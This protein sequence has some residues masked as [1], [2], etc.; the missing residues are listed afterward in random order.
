MK[1]LTAEEA[2]A[3]LNIKPQTVARRCRNGDLRGFKNG[4][5]W[6]LSEDDLRRHVEAGE[7]VPDP[8][9]RRRKRRAA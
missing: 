2:A 5:Q 4:R 6:L 7:N 8:D 3:V 1:Y 9:T